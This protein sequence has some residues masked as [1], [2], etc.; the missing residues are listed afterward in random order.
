MTVLLPPD[1]PSET[2]Q[3]SY[4]L[5]GPF[6]GYGGYTD[7][8]PNLNFYK[9]AASID[10]KAARKAPLVVYAP[11]CDFQT[12]SVP[13][14]SD[15]AATAQF[16]CAHVPVLALSGQIEPG[17]L[18]AKKKTDIEIY[19]EAPWAM[20]LFALVD[21]MVSLQSRTGRL[22]SACPTSQSIPRQLNRMPL[23]GWC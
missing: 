12:F 9:I 18:V 4:E 3:V 13:L 2:V 16:E 21:G 11:D 19:Y 14:Q 7:P 15:S 22:L 10:G 20:K 23:F 1:I 17:G 5:T 6:G 8:A